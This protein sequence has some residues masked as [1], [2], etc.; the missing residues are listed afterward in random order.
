MFKKILNKRKNISYFIFP[1]LLTLIVFVILALYLDV[2]IKNSELADIKKNEINIVYLKKDFILNECNMLISNLHY[3]NH[4]Y[5]YKLINEEFDSI[6]K[7]WAD[8]SIERGIYHRIHYIDN[9]GDEKICINI[10]NDGGKILPKSELNNYKNEYIFKESIKLKAETSYFLIEK[11]D[12]NKGEP[13]IRFTTPIYDDSNMIKGIIM[14]DYI[15]DYNLNS[16]RKIS[17]YSGSTFYLV[18]SE[19]KI[20]ATDCGCKE[21]TFIKKYK[22]EW[23]KMKKYNSQGQFKS[24]NGLFS[25]IEASLLNNKIMRNLNN[26]EGVVYIVSVFENSNQNKIYFDNNSFLINFIIRNYIY[27]IF[28][29]LLSVTVGMLVFA[30]KKKYSK[31][32]YY[33]KYDSM[34]KAYNRRY[35]LAKLKKMLY[36]EKG[37]TINNGSLCFIDINGLKLVNDKY[38]HKFGD[39]MILGVVNIIY[40]TIRKTDFIIRLGGDEFLIVFVGMSEENAEKKWQEIIN[41]YSEFNKNAE[42]KYYIS[43]SHGIVEFG[44]NMNVEIDELIHIADKKMYAEKQEIKKTTIFENNYSEI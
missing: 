41:K 7:N 29:L 5:K 33:S 24:D 39:E 26:Q 32:K 34:T 15:A 8:F 21:D 31:I 20:L 13:L 11:N 23:S 16:L 43:V 28:V 30:N 37:M 9:T 36:E 27:L 1:F 40:S 35:G 25:F 38:G 2:K 10:D 22:N 12:V 3:L 19:G 17:A 42:N 6:A 18:S 14:I 44:N 4:A